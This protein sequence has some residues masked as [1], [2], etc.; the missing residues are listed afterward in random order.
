MLDSTLMEKLFY[1]VFFFRMVTP[2]AIATNPYPHK[3]GSHSGMMPNK[4]VRMNVS[5]PVLIKIYS[6]KSIQQ[7]PKKKYTNVEQWPTFSC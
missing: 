1:K 2:S 6:K 3:N 5:T 4:E 7:N